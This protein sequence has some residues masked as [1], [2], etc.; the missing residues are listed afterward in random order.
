MG[1]L[2]SL[3]YAAAGRRP[4]Y[5]RLAATVA[6]GVGAGLAALATNVIVDAFHDN[7]L[8]VW[9][10]ATLFVL[11]VAL[12]ISA[13]QRS[14][15]PGT[16][17]GLI[18]SSSSARRHQGAAAPRNCCRLLAGGQPT[19]AARR[20]DHLDARCRLLRW[21]PC[22]RHAARAGHLR[23]PRC[24]R[25][26]RCVQVP[27]PRRT[28]DGFLA[29]TAA[30]RRPGSVTEPVRSETAALDEKRLSALHGSSTSSRDTAQTMSRRTS[31]ISFAADMPGS[32]EPDA[33]PLTSKSS[34]RLDVWHPDGVYVNSAN[35]PDPA[36]HRGIEAVRRQIGR[37][38]DAYPDLQVEPLE[39]RPT[40][41]GRS[42]GLGSRATVQT[43]GFP[44]T[45]RWLTSTPSRV[46]NSAVS[47]NTRTAP[48]A[49]KPP[50]C[51]TSWKQ[52]LWTR[53]GYPLCIEGAL[54][55]FLRFPANRKRRGASA[56]LAR[57]TRTRRR[58]DLPGA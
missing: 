34:P 1:I 22:G 18:A 5:V 17:F 38:V 27:R 12:P 16:A 21:P 30:E 23:H 41:I 15:L 24:D 10:V 37:W 44:L 3:I 47:R 56:A 42:P 8:G 55:T 51:R 45:W 19:V 54:L 50:G 2:G 53:S 6:L 28:D 25:G 35:D 9:G 7:F 46:A 57:M 48:M 13:F 29:R 40:A 11:A 32:T 20:R 31:R 52:L 14:F 36:V 33:N 58:G 49:S 43:V 39:S 26:D 4:V